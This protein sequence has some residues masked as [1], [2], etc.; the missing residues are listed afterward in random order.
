MLRAG[1]VSISF[2]NLS[3]AA[4]ISL[5]QENRLS[6][7]EWGGDVHVP[8]GDIATAKEVRRM[9][10]DAGI[11]VACYGSYYRAG[12]DDGKN[13]PI[14]AVIES[15]LALGAP[16]IR[17]WAGR[18]GSA[19]CSAEERITVENEIEAF[20]T[21]TA[22]HNIKV[23]LEYHTRTLT[24]TPYSTSQLLDDIQSPNLYSLWQPPL[25]SSVHDN[26]TAINALGSRLANAHV[27]AWE[28]DEGGA[29]VRLPLQAHATAWSAYLRALSGQPRWVLLEFVRNN[30]PNQLRTD[31]A[32]LL[33]LIEAQS[34]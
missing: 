30:D 14:S 15:A 18:K 1:L 8:H 28:P 9:C 24:D 4:I 34:G 31:A 23:V 12:W 21:A 19:E 17:I 16:S 25:G 5:C 32:T 3:P 13:P 22:N 33:K 29:A 26:L 7:I 11:F 27:F 20:A 6:G 10:D 2:R